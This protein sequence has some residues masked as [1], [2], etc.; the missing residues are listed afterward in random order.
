ML[1]M[2]IG[3]MIQLHA[4]KQPHKYAINCDGESIT[5]EC[6]YKDILQKQQKLTSL[7]GD[8]QGKKVS[9]L[10]ENDSEFLSLFLAIASIGA[11]AIPL[12]SKWSDRDLHYI[13]EDCEPDLMITGKKRNL[14]GPNVISFEKFTNLSSSHTSIKN[15]TTGSLFYIGYTSGTTGRPKGYMRT[16]S[17][18]HYSFSGSDSIFGITE[19]DVIFSPGPLVHSH[20]L[21][22]AIHSLHKGATTFISKKFNAKHVLQTL[23]LEPITTLYLVPTM[24]SAIYDQFQREPYPTSGVDKVISAGAKWHATSKSKANDVFPNA[25][26]YEFYGASELSFV[27]FLDHQGNIERPES[28]GKPFPGVQV[29][30]RNPEGDEVDRGETG[31]LFIKSSG[32]FSGYLNQ[33]EAT[34]EV[35]LGEWASV[36]DLAYMDEEGYITLVGREKNKIISGGLNI[37]PEE[38]EKVLEEL[39]EIN[40]VAIIGL[41]DEYWGEKVVAL[42]QWKPGKILSEKELIRYCKK[43]LASYKCPQMFIE[44]A[45]FPYTTSGKIARKETV[46]LAEDKLMKGKRVIEDE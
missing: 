12:D 27:S 3:E 2:A 16:H 32:V 21:Y 6:L 34:K 35:F 17:S 9:F 13:I 38:I 45:S 42:I 15:P 46:K 40:E 11:I 25:R 10:L 39:P 28:V 36:G 18:W 4:K 22:A 43:N 29:S 19:K 23:A 5:Y 33:P 14:S 44:V 20:F 1:A 37:F 8:I 30:I 31:K 7:L 41:E 26:I 24:F